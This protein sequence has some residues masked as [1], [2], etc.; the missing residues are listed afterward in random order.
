M[1][2]TKTSCAL[3]SGYYFLFHTLSHLS[4]KVHLKYKNKM[5][6]I[7]YSQPIRMFPATH[8]LRTTELDELTFPVNHILSLPTPMSE[9]GRTYK[10][11]LK[12]SYHA[13]QLLKQ[14]QEK[15]SWNVT[16]KDKKS[17]NTHNPQL[18]MYFSLCGSQMICNLFFL[19]IVESNRALKNIY[20]YKTQLFVLSFKIT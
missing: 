14:F 18:N 5:I 11:T 15:C 20:F 6:L 12:E 2:K 19:N 10:L 16:T 8:R 17:H 1:C 4:I 9:T 3:K 7:K 13:S